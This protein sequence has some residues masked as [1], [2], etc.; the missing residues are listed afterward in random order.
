MSTLDSQHS[1]VSANLIPTSRLHLEAELTESNTV[2][3]QVSTETTLADQYP[4]NEA[5]RPTI[6]DKDNTGYYFKVLD[7]IIYK[8]F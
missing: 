6:N 1:I 7:T 3:Y 4:Q 5:N 2:A 8:H